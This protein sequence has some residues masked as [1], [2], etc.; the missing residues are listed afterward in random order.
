[1]NLKSLLR[2][3]VPDRKTFAGKVLPYVL[4]AVFASATVFAALGA[5]TV[6][7]Q[8]MTVNETKAELEAALNQSQALLSQLTEINTSTKTLL[9][10]AEGEENAV[11]DKIEQLQTAFENIENKEQQRWIL[12]L[13]YKVC[14]SYFGYRD[15]PLAEATKFHYGVDLAA[16]LGTPVVASRS[17]T[18]TTASYEADNAGYYVNIDHLDG[19]SSRY[20][21]MQKY[22]V[23]EG[24]FVMAGQIIGYCGATGAATGSHLHFGIYHN[25]EAVNPADYIDLY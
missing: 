5:Q 16:D 13:Q 15:H 12:P 25:D 19:Y 1:M 17:G 23:T 14:T 11:A 22:I 10:Q 21:H 8:Y 20:M 24:Q 7:Q 6:E 2:I 3:H 18:V 9:E 4:V